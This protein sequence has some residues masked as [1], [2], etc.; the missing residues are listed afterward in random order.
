MLVCIC[1]HH[2]HYRNVE[3]VLFHDVTCY[4]YSLLS[5]IHVNIAKFFMCTLVATTVILHSVECT[6]K[7][8]PSDPT[9]HTSIPHSKFMYGKI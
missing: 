8:F 4:T 2:S 3:F 9:Q 1:C 6:R 7:L 5:R